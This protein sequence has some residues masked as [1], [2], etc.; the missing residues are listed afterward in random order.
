MQK[1]L[2]HELLCT[3][4]VV[5]SAVSIPR[6]MSN[7]EPERQLIAIIFLKKKDAY[8]AAVKIIVF[9][10]ILLKHLM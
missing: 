6:E 8:D 2:R 3:N 1:Q 7:F 5:R 10:L 4:A 9:L